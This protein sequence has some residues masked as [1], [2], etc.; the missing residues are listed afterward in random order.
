MRIAQDMGRPVPEGPMVLAVEGTHGPVVHGANRSA[1][2]LGIRVGERIVDMRAL[3][4]ELRVEYGDLSGDNALMERLVLWIR[5][6]GPWSARDGAH[7]LILDCT[8][9]PHLFGGEA[10]L[11]E[12]IEARLSTLGLSARVAMATTWGAAWALARFGAVRA[13]CEGNEAEA[14]RPLPVRALRLS[15]EAEQLLHR[16]GLKTIGDLAAIPRLSLARRFNRAELVA[17]PLLRLDQAMGRMAEP[18]SAED[19]PEPTRSILRLAEPIQ[20]PTAH[21]PDLCAE[22]C[23]QLAERGAGCRRLHLT[24]YRTD[25]EVAC[26]TVATSQPSRDPAHLARLFDGR[27]ERIDPGFGFDLVTLDADGVEPFDEVQSDLGGRRAAGMSLPQLIDRLSAR[28]GA[29][30]VTRPVT[31]ESHVPERAERRVPALHDAPQGEVTTRERP[32]RIL[33]SPEEVRVIYAVPEGPPAQFI[34]RKQTLRVARHAG[35]ER[36]APEWWRD[37]PGTRLRD[38]YKVEDEKGLRLWLY[39]EGLDGDGRGGQPRWFVHG[40]FA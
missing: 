20:D 12:E 38:Y 39:R 17:N 32:L 5:R 23:A 37:K 25:G 18:I 15:S 6:W 21:L 16:L 26:V 24:V 35:P 3:C 7:G 34:W 29:E 1:T 2:M 40:I 8:G 14:L 31:C 19:A 27:L 28:F 9:V 30:A 36:I 10:A 33:P 22:L 11:L 4:P 13:I